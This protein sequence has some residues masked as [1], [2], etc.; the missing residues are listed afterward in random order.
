MKE[1]GHFEDVQLLGL[2]GENKSEIISVGRRGI[3]IHRLG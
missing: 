2:Q 3:K 1:K